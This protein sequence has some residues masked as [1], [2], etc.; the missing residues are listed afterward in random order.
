M[1][2]IDLPAL[3]KG[4]AM[5]VAIS[6][7][8]A[9]LGGIVEDDTAQGVILVAIL[10]GFAAGGFV[11]GRTAAEN[12]YSTGALAAF[13]GSSVVQLVAIVVGIVEGSGVPFG[14]IVFYALV[15]YGCGLTG[16]VAG[17]RRARS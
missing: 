14:P 16:A 4:A 17:A 10:L 2:R 9:V 1:P 3:L 11:A 13:A 15:S 5:T 7:P 6:L 8:T 12:P